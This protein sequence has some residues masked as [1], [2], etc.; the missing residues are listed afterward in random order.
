MWVT[1]LLLLGT[2]QTTM[3]PVAAG[4]SLAVTVEGA[5]DPIVLIPG[6]LG[7]GY[8]YRT[9]T[10]LLN[11]EGYQTF[12]IEPLGVGSSSRPRD[13]DYSLYAQTARLAATLDSLQVGPVYLLGHAVGSAI[14]L[15]LAYQ[16]PGLVLG[17]IS[18]EGGAA[19]T[20]AT[21]G[22]QRA[23]KLAPLIKLL[24]VGF[25]R[26]KIRGQFLSASGETSWVSD[27]VVAGYTAHAARDFGAAIDG[28]RAMA[29]SQ[30]PEPLTPHLGEIRCPV[31]LL[32][33]GVP[34]EGGPNSAEVALLAEQ[35][36]AFAADT[37]PHV[38]HFLHEEAPATV[39]EAVNRVRA[40][41]TYLA[42][43]FHD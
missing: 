16:R 29:R 31:Y 12:V 35:I 14:A 10:P 41:A 39:V 17:V 33:G 25:L 38:G 30:E 42:V 22:F 40:T 1:L 11:Q 43:L 24:G 4:E 23:M 28:Y 5:G 15:R 8:A 34:H 9:L 37:I 19:E 6:L 7:S 36:P 21:P 27:S 26:G 3:V 32:L 18:L 20:A 2:P 13:A